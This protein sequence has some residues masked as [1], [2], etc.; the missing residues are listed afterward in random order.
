MR[1]FIVAANKSQANATAVIDMK[2]KA[3]NLGWTDAE[4]NVIE[5]AQSTHQLRG[6]ERGTIIYLGYGWHTNIDLHDLPALAT[7]N[8]YRLHPIDGGGE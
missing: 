8:E 2:W 4:G 5:Y 3:D 1:R 6:L 7:F